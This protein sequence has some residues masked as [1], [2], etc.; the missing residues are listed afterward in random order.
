MT[1]SNKRTSCRELFQDLGILPLCSQY[2]LSLALF[3]AKNMDDFIINSDI[4]PCNTRYNTNLHPPLARLTK[5]Q[6]GVYYS[7]IK[8]YNCLLIRIKQLLGDLNK[9]K[10]ALRKCLLVGSFYTIEE[11]LKCSALSILRASYSWWLLDLAGQRSYLIKPKPSTRSILLLITLWDITL[12][13]NFIVIVNDL[14]IKL[15]QNCTVL[16]YMSYST[17]IYSLNLWGIST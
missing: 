4:H 7:D 13:Y 8:V 5:Y 10:E 1:N 2:I 15:Q 3:V 14:L 6:K 16:L 9:F 11:F 17:L 12:S